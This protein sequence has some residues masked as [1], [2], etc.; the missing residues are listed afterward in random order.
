MVRRLTA[1]PLI[2]V[3]LQVQV[4]PIIA[5]AIMTTIHQQMQVQPVMELI[6][7]LR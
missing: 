7:T 3:V 2:Q 6:A 4:Q 1:R 5:I